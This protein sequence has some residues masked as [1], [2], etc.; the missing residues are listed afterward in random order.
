MIP[1]Q[2]AASLGVPV[3]QARPDDADWTME[4]KTGSADKAMSF[5]QRE[6]HPHP[7]AKRILISTFLLN[8]AVLPVDQIVRDQLAYRF[9]IT[10]EKAFLTGSGSGQPLGVFTASALR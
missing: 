6:L 2:K 1:V 7:A 4:L 9:G 3:L 5:G 8:N 10:Q